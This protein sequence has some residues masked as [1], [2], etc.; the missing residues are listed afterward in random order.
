[1]SSGAGPFT[2]VNKKFRSNSGII[3]C[4]VLHPSNTLTN[5]FLLLLGV[6]LLYGSFGLIATSLAP[7]AEIVIEDLAMTHGE[8]GLIMGAW[9]LIYIFSAVPAGMLLDRIGTKKALAIGGSLIALSAFARSGAS[10]FSELL[11]AVM[12]FGLGGPIIS[13]GAPKAIVSA[14]EGS[15]RGLAMGIYM[16]GPAIGAIVS[17]TL[18]NSFLLP[19]FEGDWRNVML[20]WGFFAVS[21]TTLWFF[22]PQSCEERSND[23][24]E[25]KESQVE[26]VFELIKKPTVMLV[27]ILSACVFTF[28]HGLNNWLPEL[29]K[30]H[31]FSSVFSGY[32]AALPIFVGII[33]SLVIPRLATPTRRFKI[34][35]L[36]CF[37]AFLSSLLLQFISLDVLVPG[38]IL[39][40]LARASLMTVLILT[41]VELPEIGEKRAGTASGM[42]FSAAEMGGLLGPL[43]LGILYEPSLG[44]SSGLIFLSV[45][46][47]FMI[48]GA[49]LLGRSAR[50]KQ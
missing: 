12:L 41:L 3:R 18:T 45:I 30:S 28:N 24:L 16:T 27:L 14:F 6:W 40:G 29:L 20:L 21:A 9:Q 2:K 15:A 43:T 26:V 39:Q 7:I 5:K 8:M 48:I 42:F 25:T 38:L 31:G 36:L 35:F 44:F 33:G 22:L 13:A 23:K 49:L 50:G 47:G 17:L 34:L 37:A 46:S 11:G 10:D 4:Y 32:L 1:M 19:V